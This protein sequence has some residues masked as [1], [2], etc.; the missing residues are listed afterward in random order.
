M[1][2]LLTDRFVAGRKPPEKGQAEF[3][4]TKVPGLSLRV[5]QGGSRAWSMLYSRAGRRVRIRLGAYPT[6][7]LAAAR[8]AALEAKSVIEE[9]GDPRAGSGGTLGELVRVLPRPARPPP[10]AK[11]A[12]G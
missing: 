2:V 4:D 11:R 9:G 1:R 10:P 12:D 8:T 6:M 3:F 7:Q 5:S